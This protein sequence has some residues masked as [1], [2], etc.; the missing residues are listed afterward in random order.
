MLRP[1]NI[2][3]DVF[4]S[5]SKIGIKQHLLLSIIIT[6]NFRLYLIVTKAFFLLYINV[7]MP[8]STKAYNS[9][10]ELNQTEALNY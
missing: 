2:K 3:T 1:G 7:L 8:R 5:A 10:V 4:L 9:R 6:I